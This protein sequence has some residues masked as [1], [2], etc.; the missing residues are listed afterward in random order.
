MAHKL[1]IGAFKNTA[2]LFGVLQ[3]ACVL[4]GRL[5][6]RKP[7]ASFPAELAVPLDADEMARITAMRVSPFN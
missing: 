7:L 4:A 3:G 6:A 1:V 5:C 2:E